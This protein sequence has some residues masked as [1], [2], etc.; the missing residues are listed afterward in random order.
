MRGETNNREAG[1]LGNTSSRRD[2][3]DCAQAP[4]RRLRRQRLILDEAAQPLRAARV[5]Q[6]PQRLGLDLPD[7]LARHLEVLSHFLEGVIGLLPDAEAHAEHLLLA[8][9]ERRQHLPRL[10]REV[11]VDHRVGGRGDGLV[12]DEVAEVAVLLLADGSLQRDGLLGDLQDLAHLV[13]RELHLLRNFLRS[14]LAADLLHQVARGADQLVDRL[15]H[16]HRDADGAGLIGDGAGD[17]LPD[18]PGGV[19]GELVAALVLELVDRLHQADVALLDQVEE[20]QPA[21]R[22]LLRDRHHQAQVG[23]DQLGLGLLRLALS[24]DDGAVAPLQLVDRQQRL[25]LDALHLPRGRRDGAG[26]LSHFLLG[27]A[28][29]L[30]FL[31]RSQTALALVLGIAQQPLELPEADAQAL[32]DVPHLALDLVDALDQLL[33]VL[34]DALDLALVQLHLGESLRH[35][36]LV[37]GDGVA[38]LLALALGDLAGLGGHQLGEVLVLAV[39]AADAVDQLH[40]LVGATLLVE[41]LVVL[42]RRVAD[43]FAHA[44]LALLQPLA[45]L[46]D[47]LDRDAGVE[48]GVEH[49]LLAV[50]DALGDLH[51]ALA[52]EQGDRAHLAQVHAHR[53]V[54]FGVCVLLLLLRLFLRGR[55]IF[56]LHHYRFRLGRLRLGK[57]DLVG[58][59]DDGDVVVAE[60]RHHVVDLVGG[61]DVRRQRVVDLVVG[62]EALVAP[63]CEQVLH[64]LALGGL[65]ALLG[66]REILVFVLFDVRRD[67]VVVAYVGNGGGFDLRLFALRDLFPFHLVVALRRLL[68]LL[69][70]LVL[71]S[72][73]HLRGRRFRLAHGL[74]VLLR[75][76]RSLLLALAPLR[77]GFGG[78]VLP[79]GGCGLLVGHLGQLQCASAVGGRWRVMD[80]MP[81]R[82][83][84]SDRFKPL[85]PVAKRAASAPAPRFA[86]VFLKGWIDALRQ[87]G[88]LPAP[89]LPRHRGPAASANRARRRG[90]QSGHH[91]PNRLRPRP[92]A[93]RDAR[94]RPRR[95]SEPARAPAWGCAPAPRG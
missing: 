72:P 87:C 49:F 30:Q 27:E 9:R 14:G 2:R 68:R 77:L 78:A 76:R 35:R 93:A 79:A 69:R 86:H 3:Y 12:L 46:D 28:Q 38:V 95:R 13:E 24:G 6:F 43:H 94:S 56:L 26:H 57:L 40:H 85:E 5:P 20:L 51:L 89:S 32:L 71:L 10:L 62:E 21:V 15:D 61:D 58:L 1:R 60:H 55:L 84:F 44:H 8:R 19:G 74:Q 59:V 53:I 4:H 88:R 36:R 67:L 70:R 47:L 11:H 29:D 33:E 31:A 18:P 81:Y 73:L 48:H 82:P 39:Q 41:G 34:D 23:L 80:G 42:V 65:A 37:A 17:G 16:V 50:L 7:A 83:F 52:G 54:G 66:R 92:R 45:D 91:A 64:F 75:L 22:V 90:S 25:F 63:E